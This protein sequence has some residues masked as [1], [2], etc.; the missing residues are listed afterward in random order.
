MF[1]ASNYFLLTRTSLT[2]IT[3]IHLSAFSPACAHKHTPHFTIR[4]HHL[5]RDG[6]VSRQVAFDSFYLPEQLHWEFF[7]IDR[8]CLG[9]LSFV[10]CSEPPPLGRF[11]IRVCVRVCVAVGGGGSY[12]PLLL[13]IGRPRQTQHA[14]GHVLVMHAHTCTR[15]QRQTESHAA[16]AS[17]FERRDAVW[18]DTP[19]ALQW[20]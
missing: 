2:E 11:L 16:V 12:V 5:P 10:A 14:R 7:L 20:L 15:S 4:S 1:L 17:C 13:C 9:K 19:R 3:V 18:S 8:S 6:A